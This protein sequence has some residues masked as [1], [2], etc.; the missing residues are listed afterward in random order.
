M[1][2]GCE[3]ATA[4]EELFAV[5]VSCCQRIDDHVARA[6]IESDYN[7]LRRKQRNVSNAADVQGHAGK[8]SMG[9]K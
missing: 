7:A 6:C 1:A 3:R 2:S 9:E 4:V 5:G 8:L